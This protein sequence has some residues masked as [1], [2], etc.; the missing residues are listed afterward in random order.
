MKTFIHLR[1]FID[2]YS[3]RKHGTIIKTAYVSF[4]CRMV[5]PQPM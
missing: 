2:N 1:L 5:L 4:V 3:T